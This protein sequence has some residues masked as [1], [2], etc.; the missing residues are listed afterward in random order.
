MSAVDR[1]RLRVCEYVWV[2]ISGKLLYTDSRGDTDF[3]GTAPTRFGTEDLR[4]ATIPETHPERIMTD[5]YTKHHFM[6]H[7]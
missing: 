6:W 7:G 1:N 5:P 2:G 3:Y 4:V